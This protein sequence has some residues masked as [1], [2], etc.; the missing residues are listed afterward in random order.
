[1]EEEINRYKTIIGAYYGVMLMDEYSLKAYVLK[2]IENLAANYLQDKNIE[3]DGIKQFI[4]DKV[5]KKVKLQDALYI[6]NELD[7]D[8]ELLHLI[9][10]KIRTLESENDKND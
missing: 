4:R 8:K 3:T 9:K 7:E 1:M 6:L 5:S 2:N 10:K